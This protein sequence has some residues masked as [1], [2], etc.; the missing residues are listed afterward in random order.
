VAGRRILLL[1][2]IATY[3]RSIQQAGASLQAGGA[4]T[5]YA[6]ILAYT[7]SSHC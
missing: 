7:E 3:R 4:E 2:D 6:V 1:D 5:V